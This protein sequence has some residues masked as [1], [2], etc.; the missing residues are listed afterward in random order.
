MRKMQFSPEL[1]KRVA[2]ITFSRKL[3]RPNYCEVSFNNV[4]ISDD[5][6]RK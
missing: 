6:S 3:S 4:L 2:K 1:N 5:F